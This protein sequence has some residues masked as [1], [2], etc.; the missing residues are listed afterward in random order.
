MKEALSQANVPFRPVDITSGMLPL[1]QFLKYRDNCPQF[2]A[3]RE[4]GRIGIP[5]LVINKGKEI[6]F[7]L[8][9]D[10]SELRGT[11]E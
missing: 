5:C 9:E 6:L 8:P 10:L 7:T 11:E 4:Q 2:D 3:M 1:K